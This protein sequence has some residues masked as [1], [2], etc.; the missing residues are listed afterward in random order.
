MEESLSTLIDQIP[1]GIITYSR[2]GFVEYINKNFHKFGIL[3]QFNYPV[4]GV[5]LF[6]FKL[7]NFTDLTQDLKNIIKGSS[8]E[9]EIKRVETQSGGHI[10]LFI[11]GFPIYEEENISGGMLI[12]EDLKI[13]ASTDTELKLKSKLTEDYLERSED[14][15]VVTDTAG[16]IKFSTGKENSKLQLFRKEITGKNIG[17]V[18]NSTTKQKILESFSIAVRQRISQSVRLEIRTEETNTPA[19]CKIDPVIGDNGYV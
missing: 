14:F 11:K 8:F 17:E 13:L 3:Y 2:D 19:D 6:E 18:F 12:V 10:S 4:P 1:L 7:F 15:I 16:D 9:K 5:N